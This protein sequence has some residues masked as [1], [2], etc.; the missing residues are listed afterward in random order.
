MSVKCET[1]NPSGL[2]LFT[3]DILFRGV[4]NICKREGLL[5]KRGKSEKEGV[6]GVSH[7]ALHPYNI[8]PVYVALRHNES[9]L[10]KL[11]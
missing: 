8:N 10:S 3:Y 7:Y 1:K 9:K 5:K 2:F 4:A 6:K 11:I